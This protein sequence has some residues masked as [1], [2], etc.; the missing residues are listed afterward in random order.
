MR[1]ENLYAEGHMVDSTEASLGDDVLSPGWRGGYRKTYY[2]Q[3]RLG[4]TRMR[5]DDY[6][7]STCDYDAFGN[8]YRGGM[9][10]GKPVDAFTGLYNYGFRDYSP[11]Q[12]RF[13]TAD[14]I[15]DGLNWYAYVGN[16]PVNR[17]DLWGLCAE[18]TEEDKLTAT[19]VP[20]AGA[21]LTLIVGGN[22]DFAYV[23]DSSGNK[24]IA[25]TA[26]AGVGV[27]A[28]IDIPDVIGVAVNSLVSGVDDVLGIKT[29]EGT[30]QDFEG[31]IKTTSVHIVVGLDQDLNDPSDTNL[32]VDLSIGGG[33]YI[34]YTKVIKIVDGGDE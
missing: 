18:S 2:S 17:I 7:F 25:I 28:D 9:G 31:V 22:V 1:R 23:Y 12:M 14:P 8:C 16:A 13:T 24:G 10:E 11:R 27:E 29:I 30:I 3:D 33:V 26:E 20:I 6:T 5:R 15:K 19:M 21:G 34:G 32:S 4:S